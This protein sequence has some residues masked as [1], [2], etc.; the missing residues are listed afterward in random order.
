VDGGGTKSERADVGWAGGD[1][2]RDSGSLKAE[3]R[4][5]SAKGGTLSGD[6]WSWPGMTPSHAMDGVG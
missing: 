2:S 5:E 1:T 6:G 4:S 3:R